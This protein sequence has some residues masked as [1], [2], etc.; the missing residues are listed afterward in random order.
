MT[1]TRIEWQAVNALGVPAMKF[2]GPDPE[3][4]ARAWAKANAHRHDGLVVQRVTITETVE[5][6]YRPRVRQAF[7]FT[8]PRFDQAHA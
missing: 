5:P 2:S 3:R 4:R 1:Q 6:V 8:I 7:D